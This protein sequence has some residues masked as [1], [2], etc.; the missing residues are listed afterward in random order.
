VKKCLMTIRAD[1]GVGRTYE[2]NFFH[3]DFEQFG[4]QYSRYQD[5]LPSIVLSQQCRE[6]YFITFTV[7]NPYWDLTNKRY[8]NRPI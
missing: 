6:V 4:K 5:I 3:H 7:V 1:P 2:S 8:W